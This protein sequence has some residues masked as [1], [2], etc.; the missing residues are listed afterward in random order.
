[1]SA[2]DKILNETTEELEKPIVNL[3]KDL[4]L[5]K[6]KRVVLQMIVINLQIGD[7]DFIKWTETIKN[8]NELDNYINEV[9]K[10]Y[11]EVIL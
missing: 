11:R 8:I 4:K 7:E 2:I 3:A 6:F 5:D 10:K 1:M 9:D